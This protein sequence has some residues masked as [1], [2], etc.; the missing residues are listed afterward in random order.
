MGRR[1][2][3]RPAVALQVIVAPLLKASVD[4]VA[5]VAVERRAI[6]RQPLQKEFLVHVHD[7][8]LALGGMAGELLEE[9]DGQQKP[10]TSK[11]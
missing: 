6:V 7:K 5:G 3:D 9:Q 8:K 10:P 2:R 1:T 4:V 11:W